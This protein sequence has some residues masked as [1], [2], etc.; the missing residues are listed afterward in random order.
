[1]NHIK[2][3]IVSWLLLFAVGLQAETY[4]PLTTGDNLWNIAK[5]VRPNDDVRIHQVMLAL[6]RKNPHAFSIPCNIN[7]LKIDVTLTV[8]TLA[9]MQRLSYAQAVEK[10]NRHNEIWKDYRRGRIEEIDCDNQ[11]I[12]SAQK[13]MSTTETTTTSL[14]SPLEASAS[15]ETL[16]PGQTGEPEPN[17]T[18]PPPPKREPKE[19]SSEEEIKVVENDTRNDT[20]KETTEEEK[21]A[22]PPKSTS[23]GQSVAVANNADNH[24][25][26]TALNADNSAQNQQNSGHHIALWIMLGALLFFFLLGYFLRHRVQ[27]KPIPDDLA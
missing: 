22:S 9:E 21:L 4:G 19:H 24:L 3:F 6:W 23:E 20:A 8:P 14:P 27:N 12:A 13:R 10:Y 16:L 7:S 15:E 17:T 25:Q 2:N 11:Q 18:P 1:M 5:K 26:P